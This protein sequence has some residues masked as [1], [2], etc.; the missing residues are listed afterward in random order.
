MKIETSSVCEIGMVR[1]RN[2]DSI[3]VHCDDARQFAMFIVADGMGGYSDGER[4][5]NAIVSGMRGWLRSNPVPDSGANVNTLLRQAG[6]QLE[7][8]N[9]YVLEEWNRNQVCGSTCVLLMTLRDTYGFI[10]VGDSR[11]YMSRGMKCEQI[12]RDD[13]WENQAHIR[14]Q[15]TEK[16]IRANPNY[17]KLA[18]ALGNE[19]HL[20]YSMQSEKLMRKDVFALC[21]DGVYKMC[22]ERFLKG[23]IR[24]CQRKNLDTVRDEI[25]S[26]VRRGGAK[27]NASLIL[28]R[29]SDF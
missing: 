17:G 21:S 3:L 11:I 25:M 5:S 8:I 9:R 15:L 6:N 16:E 26:E 18:S 27:D 28:V 13:V 2:Q 1:K 22:A 14:R 29:C 7:D 10:S 4:A 19:P 23:R 20:A 12:T 24:A